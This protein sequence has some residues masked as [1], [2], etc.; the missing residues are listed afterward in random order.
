MKPSLSSNPT[1][2]AL[3]AM[4]CLSVYYHTLFFGITHVDDS[5]LLTENIAYLRHLPNILKALTT[6]AFYRTQTIDLYRP[7]QTVSFFLDTLWGFDLVWTAHA[8]NL[9]LHMATCCT[10]F[11]LLLRLEFRRPVALAGALIY[12]VHYLFSS[13]VIWIPARG[14]L[15][16][17]LF[18]FQ[19]LMAGIRLIETNRWH[20]YVL[21]LFWF[22]LALFAK[23]TA[24]VLPFLFALYLW[25]ANA[26]Q[27]INKRYLVLL[28]SYGAVV[29]LHA[30]LRHAAV[31]ESA[32]VTGVGP[33]LKNLPVIP[34]TVAR[35]FVP[36]N[37]S[38]LPAFQPLA[39]GTGIVIILALGCYFLW[40]KPAGKRQPLFAV[41][42]F[43]ALLTPSLAYYPDFYF[44]CYE[45]IDHR[46]YLV[47]FGLL[48]IVLHLVQDCQLDRRRG[49][50]A[51]VL[52]ILV[53]L[54]A[55]NLHYSHR[56]QN[57]LEF[58]KLAMATNP[59]SALGYSL[60][61]QEMLAQ[62]NVEAAL[63]YFTQS[64]RICPVLIPPLQLRAKIYRQRQLDREAL[65]DLNAILFTNPDAGAQIYIDRAHVKVTLEN[66]TG[67][68]QDFTAA[69]RL[70]KD[71]GQARKGAGEIRRTVVNNRLLPHVRQAIDANRS[72]VKAAEA[73]DYRTAL[74]FFRQALIFDPG[75]H[76]L[77]VN[78]GHCL[79]AL[80]DRAGACTAWEQ[81]AL[82]DNTL[83]AS[84]LQSECPRPEQ[85]KARP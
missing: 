71:N 8:T 33:F 30:S 2:F 76:D 4:V 49:F 32:Q 21:H 19:A 26:L 45:H 37:I 9:L 5:M 67:A 64:L 66:Y 51:G 46:A 13:A 11:T 72:G 18:T 17:A 57:R 62:G 54:V 73:G 60:Y 20:H 12:A 28:G 48:L 34:E 39:T 81:A 50:T 35:F 58:A 3:L 56:Y 79:R 70:D 7:L 69:L 14:D 83:A 80:G 68:L 38:T 59:K 84:L 15:L 42:W 85:K 6:D 53:Y 27:R 23:E 52:L 24:V 1:V 22:T 41:A 61:G 78:I 40:R 16:L 31:K 47:C 29:A 10:V 43:V 25:T 55:V 82:H 74:A 36:V 75:F 65:A 63:Q 77:Q 44:F